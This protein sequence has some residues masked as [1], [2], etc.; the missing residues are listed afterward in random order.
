M[1]FSPYFDF[2]YSTYE[3]LQVCNC[4]NF[5]PSF[6]LVFLKLVCI[7][8]LYCHIILFVFFYST[9][10]V[11][12]ELRSLRE[13]DYRNFQIFR[14]F[15]CR[16]IKTDRYRLFNFW[17]TQRWFLD[18]FW[19]LLIGCS[20]TQTKRYRMFFNRYLIDCFLIFWKIRQA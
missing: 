3:S 12:A 18:D 17:L 10:P 11:I 14:S 5:L 16:N 6:L 20:G 19:W 4:E 9:H 7:W 8:W 13:P 2:A 15:S 1:F